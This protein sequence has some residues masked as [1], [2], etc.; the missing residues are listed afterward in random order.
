MQINDKM[1]YTFCYS[2]HIIVVDSTDRVKYIHL[3]LDESATIIKQNA[4]EA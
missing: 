3:Q 4:I 2:N 1:E